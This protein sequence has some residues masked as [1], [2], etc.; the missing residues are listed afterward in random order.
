M[1]N[2]LANCRGRRS[3]VFSAPIRFIIDA[4]S[5]TRNYKKTL[6]ISSMGKAARTQPRKCGKR[7]KHTEHL[8]AHKQGTQATY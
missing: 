1:S 7:N 3:V 6:Q 8:H 2:P 4:C 5:S